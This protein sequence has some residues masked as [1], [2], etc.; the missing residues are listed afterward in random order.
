M[1]VV[2]ALLAC[3]PPD[4]GDTGPP[5]RAF[6]VCGGAPTW[7]GRPALPAPRDHHATFA[8]PDADGAT[9]WVAGGNDYADVRNDTWALALGPDGPVGDWV[10]GPDL[11]RRQAGAAVA[12]VDGRV[13]LAGGRGNTALLD[14]VFVSDHDGDGRLVGWT[15]GPSLP[16]A[17]FHASAAVVGRTIVVTGG[18]DADGEATDTVVAADLAADGTLSAWRALDPLPAPRSHHAAFAADG[19]LYLTFGFAGNA[20]T[21]ATEPH[22]DVIAATLL[23]D[24]TLGPWVTVLTHD[25]AVATH[26]ATVADGCVLLPGGLVGEGHDHTAATAVR[27]LDLTDGVGL[28]EALPGP[29]IGRSHLHQAPLV[30]GRLYL[31]GGS[32]DLQEVTGAVEIGAF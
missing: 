22:G 9:L 27:R 23:D 20:F 16:D 2:L 12:E 4:G 14:A 19:R 24:G 5:A 29:T 15:D 8:V 6:D 26:A 28:P 32:P 25:L 21:N 7:S 3:T 1:F 17:R 13:I 31:V 11:P 30:D 10:E 18:V